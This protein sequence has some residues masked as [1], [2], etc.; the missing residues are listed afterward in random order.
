MRK[1]ISVKNER[2]AIVVTPPLRPAILA[3]A[4]CPYPIHCSPGQIITREKV[5]PYFVILT[6][7]SRSHPR[8]LRAS[9]R[10]EEIY[11]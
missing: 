7:S 9:L 3:E 5:Y 11:P 1:H 2:G 6:H 8:D 4:G 10:Y